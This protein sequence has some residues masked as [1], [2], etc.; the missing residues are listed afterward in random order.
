[1]TFAKGRGRAQAFMSEIVTQSQTTQRKQIIS[2]HTNVTQRSFK[3][4]T[5][6]K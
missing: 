5:T 4:L 1:M 2:W 6:Y 3:L